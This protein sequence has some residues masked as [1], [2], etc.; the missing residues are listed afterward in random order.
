MSGTV[1]TLHLAGPEGS[2]AL[3]AKREAL[4]AILAGMGR[5]LVAYSGGVDSAALLV[6]ARAVLGD[7]AV[8]VIAR[9]PS[10]PASELELAL[11][12]AANAGVAVRVVETRE[13]DRP[14]YRA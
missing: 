7:R 5:T 1:A 10:L 2:G 4:H 6:E 8:G 9:S 14:R 12:T 11:R 13:L 3:E